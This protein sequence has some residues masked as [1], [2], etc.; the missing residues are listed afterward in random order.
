MWHLTPDPA[1]EGSEPIL[2]SILTAD[3]AHRTGP[4]HR[5]CSDLSPTAAMSHLRRRL[6]RLILE[7]ERRRA[8]DAVRERALTAGA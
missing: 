4:D 8:A 2:I 7:N 1:F 3:P 5:N 6:V